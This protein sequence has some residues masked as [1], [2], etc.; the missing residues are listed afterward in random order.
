ML[1]DPEDPGSRRHL[2]V[3]LENTLTTAGFVEEWHGD[4]GDITREKVFTRAVDG[5]PDVR[6]AVYTTIVGQ[7]HDAA[8]RAVGKDAIR[9]CAVYRSQ[10]TDQERGIIKETRIH[11]TGDTDAICERMLER[12]RTVWKAAC[13]PHRCPSCNAPTFKSKAGNDVC[14]DLCFKPIDQLSSGRPMPAPR[15]WHRW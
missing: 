15:R 11:R 12:M 4:A 6:V 8:V 5:V 3:V 7:G 14:A 9:V 1:Y 2:A 13:R 10:R